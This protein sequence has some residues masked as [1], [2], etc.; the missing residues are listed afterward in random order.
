MTASIGSILSNARSA[1]SA[2]QAAINTAAHNIANAET[3]GYTRKRVEL[4]PGT[5]LVMPYGALGTGVYINDIGQV[6]DRLLDVTFRRQ[7]ADASGF[8]RRG[9]L[10]SQIENAYAGGSGTDLGAAI[11]AF[12]GGW[13][14]LATNPLNDSARVVTRQ[15]GQHLAGQLQRLNGA[16]DQVSG[17]ADARLRQEVADLSMHAAAV[18][19]LNENIVAAEAG[20]QTAG[21][22]R[23]ARDRSIDAIAKLAAVQV[24]ERADG[25]VTVAAG[26]AT[27]VDGNNSQSLSVDTTG[28]TYRIRSS[29]GTLITPAGGSLDAAMTVLNQD[30]PTARAELD[31]IART[32][33]TEVNALHTAG[34]NPLGQT[35]VA[36]F[37]DFGDVNTVTAANISLSAAVTADHRAIAAGA[38]VTDPNGGPDMYAAGAND[39]ALGLAALRNANVAAL[40]NTTI[41]G[42]YASAAVRIGS[43]VRGAADG[44]E[45]HSTLASQ[46]DSRRISVSGVSIDEELTLLIRYQNAYSAAARVITAAD[47]LFQTVI[48]MM[49]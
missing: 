27:I 28:G 20:G 35:G 31:T 22:L 47:E 14:D 42:F 21:D 25:S 7:S 32:L 43:D 2:N 13:G 30:I 24:F 48:G 17:N 49:R 8:E 37:N 34:T 36:F 11:D 46:A 3:P 38:G 12:W 19:R 41:G 29:R 6:R 16:L 18:A 44:A 33:V 40:G 10:L 5:P 1:L 39:V 26:D 45:I 23:D 15:S 4:T 9:E